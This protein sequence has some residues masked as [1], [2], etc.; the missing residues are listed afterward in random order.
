MPSEVAGS[1]ACPAVVVFAIARTSYGLRVAIR[2][3]SPGA[4]AAHASG[5]RAARTPGPM[6]GWSLAPKGRPFPARLV[7][8]PWRPHL[9]G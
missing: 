2:S 1:A 6:A 7:A 5:T 3:S 4:P 9:P 8:A